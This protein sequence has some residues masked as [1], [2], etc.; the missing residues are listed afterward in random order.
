MANKENKQRFLNAIG[1]CLKTAACTVIHSKA[2]ADLLIIQTAIESSRSKLTTVIM[3]D[4]Y[5][6]VLLAHYFQPEYHDVLFHS[7]KSNKENRT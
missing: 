3:E 4:T 1:S 6:L 2:D 5:L 7:D